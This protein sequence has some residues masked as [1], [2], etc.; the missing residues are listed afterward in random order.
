MEFTLICPND[1]RMDLGLEDI[2]AVVFRG[3][4]SVEVVFECPRCGATLRAALHVPNLMMAAMELARF[5]EDAGEAPEAHVVEGIAN[6]GDQRTPA[7]RRE[8]AQRAERER[9][10]EPY[11]EYFR[12]QLAR[13]E[14]VEDLLAETE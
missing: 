7:E 5:A 14:C 12:R 9:A 1:G 10:G 11:C 8:A 4:E 13:V 2:S 3:A 6:G